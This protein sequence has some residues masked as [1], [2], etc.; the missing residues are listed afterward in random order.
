MEQINYHKLQYD[1]TRNKHFTV[2]ERPGPT[3]DIERCLSM[4]TKS[5]SQKTSLG[6]RLNI[7]RK[8]FLNLS[9]FR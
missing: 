3:F 8:I 9:S 5:E 4:S 7:F 2:I 6:T 1:I